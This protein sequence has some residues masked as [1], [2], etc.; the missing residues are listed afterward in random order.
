MP[1]DGLGPLLEAS[2]TGSRSFAPDIARRRH[3][4]GCWSS[5]RAHV[6]TM[7]RS[8]TS[9][10]HPRRKRKQ[11]CLCELPQGRSGDHGHIHEQELAGCQSAE[12]DDQLRRLSRTSRISSIFA[13]RSFS[14]PAW[15]A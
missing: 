11:E 15:N 13:F 9:G 14:E 12:S 6:T 7:S 5:V 1:C 10:K 8:N 2:C 4:F 3:R